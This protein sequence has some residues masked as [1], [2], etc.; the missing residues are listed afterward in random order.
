MLRSAEM[1]VD[2]SPSICDYISM[3]RTFKTP[4]GRTPK[5]QPAATVWLKAYLS[6]GPRPAKEIQ[7]VGHGLGF[8]W[9]TLRRSKKES[10]FR[11]VR[12]ADMWFWDDPRVAEFAPESE[13][14]LFQQVTEKVTQ[15]IPKEIQQA[16]QIQKKQ[17]Q[18]VAPEERFVADQNYLEGI[19]KEHRR[20]KSS[21]DMIIKELLELAHKFPCDPPISDETVLAMARKYVYVP[22]VSKPNICDV[23]D[24]EADRMLAE[25]TTGQISD[26]TTQVHERKYEFRER[27]NIEGVNKMNNLLERIR[28]ALRSRYDKKQAATKVDFK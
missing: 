18:I 7:R 17:N 15:S 25:A 24:S 14:T 16:F 21:L 10:G 1:L 3:A 19:A 13:P 23:S 5:V 8:G 28:A 12:R 4:P 2:L 26:M 11:S 22:P 6:G 9:A 20:V 27:G